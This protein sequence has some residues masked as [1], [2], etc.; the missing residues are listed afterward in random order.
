LILLLTRV[1]LVLL[2]LHLG[3][4]IA[5]SLLG[6]G[7]GFLRFLLCGFDGLIGGD[8]GVRGSFFRFFLCGIHSLRGSIARGLL[9]FFAGFLSSRTRGIGSIGG[10]LF[11]LI[12]GVRSLLLGFVGR[13]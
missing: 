4:R 5:G 7:C 11:G 13:V 6:V 8:F 1:L 2:T 12:R 9:R 3:R 10:L